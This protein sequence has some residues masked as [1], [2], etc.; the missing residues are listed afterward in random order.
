MAAWPSLTVEGNLITPA[1]IS[2]I[3]QRNA[4]EQSP[5]DYNV[6]KGLKIREEIA[7][8]FRVG[9]AHCAA[10]AKLKDPQLEATKRFASGFLEEA[11]GFDDLA[12][13]SSQVDLSASDRVPI[14]VVPPNESIDR[15]S[16]TLSVERSISPAIAL[17]D[18][19]NAKEEAPGDW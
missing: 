15:R 1:M 14:V 10:F 17:Q 7:T 9:Q 4:K 16:P 13:A 5:E 2:R 12:E 6:R 11:F 19:L 8:A 18:F 3:E